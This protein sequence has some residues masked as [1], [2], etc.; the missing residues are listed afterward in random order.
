RRAIATGI[1]AAVFVVL[2]GNLSNALWYLPGSATPYDPREPAEC[3][4]SSYA[5]K[6]AC[7]GR[8]EWVFW[9]ATRIVGMSLQDST[10]TEFP[11]FTFLYG[12]LHAHMLA[13][14]L[15]LAALGLMVALIRRPGRWEGREGG[16]WRAWLLRPLTYALLPL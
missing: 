8:A 11:F 14:P 2:V 9:D 5:A 7:K 15:A 1:V 6:Q 16:R 3:Q 10:I 12:D 4:L 13:L